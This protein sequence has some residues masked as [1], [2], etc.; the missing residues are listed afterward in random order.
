M[1]NAA[2]LEKCYEFRLS[3]EPQ[4]AAAAAERHEGSAA[5]AALVSGF[6]SPSA[7]AAPMAARP[8]AMP[9]PIPEPAP[10][11]TATRPSSRTSEG[12]IDMLG[13]YPIMGRAVYRIPAKC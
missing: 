2:D 7:T 12:W 3:I 8:A 10:V 6:C 13:P 4:A 9:R 11:T 5:A 1:E